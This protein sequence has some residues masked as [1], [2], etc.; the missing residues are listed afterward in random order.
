MAPVMGGGIVN[1][2]DLYGSAIQADRIELAWDGSL[3][4][5]LVGEDLVVGVSGFGDSAPSALIYCVVQK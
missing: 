4:S 3:I 1:P 2:G 5:A